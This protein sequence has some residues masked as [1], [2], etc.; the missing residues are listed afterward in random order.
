VKRLPL[1]PLPI[2][3]LPGRPQSL[4]IFEERYRRM[5]AHCVETESPFGILYHDPDLHG[6]FLMEPDRVGCEARIE[7]FRPLPDGRSL[8][9]VRGGRRFR[10]REGSQSDDLYYEAAVEAYP[11]LPWVQG[12]GAARDRRLRSI[13]LLRAASLAMS[14]GAESDFDPSRETSYALAAHL[15][16]DPAWLQGLLELPREA[17][18]L[19]RLDAVIRAASGGPGNPTGAAGV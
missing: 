2:V 14:G 12:E 8:I 18:R 11:D 15:E 4:H 1:F 5:V 9:L 16:I 3:L 7:V 17:E 10:V 6:P 13:S 19:E